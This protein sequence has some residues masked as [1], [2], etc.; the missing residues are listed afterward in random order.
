MVRLF[1]KYNA[2]RADLLCQGEEKLGV[3]EAG[4]DEKYQSARRF[5]ATK[6]WIVQ[7]VMSSAQFGASVKAFRVEKLLNRKKSVPL[8]FH[9][10]RHS[11]EK[12]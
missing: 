3:A 12:S 8:H 11:Y 7:N 4:A 10:K 2:R 5:L 1:S 9:L 6:I